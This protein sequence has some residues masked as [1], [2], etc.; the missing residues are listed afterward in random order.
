MAL[1][2]SQ[3]HLL[4]RE[5]EPHAHTYIHTIV[6][7][8]MTRLHIYIISYPHIHYIYTHKHI[9]IFLIHTNT[10][11]YVCIFTEKCVNLCKF[12]EIFQKRFFSR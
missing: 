11:I 7:R 9:Y 2:G 6:N 12:S 8:R 1:Q 3:T 10:H 5:K 4:I